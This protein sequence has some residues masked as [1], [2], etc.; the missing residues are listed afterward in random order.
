MSK[1]SSFKQ[2]KHWLIQQEPAK[3]AELAPHKTQ[4]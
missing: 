2:F 1:N 3:N 4:F